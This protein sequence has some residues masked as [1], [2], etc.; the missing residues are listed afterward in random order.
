ML[1]SGA[2]RPMPL[3][4]KAAVKA[5]TKHAS[6]HGSLPGTAVSNTRTARQPVTMWSTV[7]SPVWAK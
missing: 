5:G 1:L 4:K 6:A 7:K 3:D 2:V